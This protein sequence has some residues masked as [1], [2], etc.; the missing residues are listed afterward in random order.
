MQSKIQRT[1]KIGEQV[2][3]RYMPHLENKYFDKR[4]FDCYVDEMLSDAN[5]SKQFVVLSKVKDKWYKIQEINPYVEYVSEWNVRYNWITPVEVKEGPIAQIIWNAIT[6][7]QDYEDYNPDRE[8]ENY[9]SQFTCDC[10]AYAY[11]I[12]AEQNDYLPNVNYE[13]VM[14]FLDSLGFIF[15][16]NSFKE[17]EEDEKRQGARFQWLHFAY[18]IAKE[19]GI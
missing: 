5:E 2:K 13:D 9:S 16:F 15:T 18:W 7:L 8:G 14:N 3:L 11:D 17:Y 10:L 12:Y 6:Y 4:Q 1:Y 19:E